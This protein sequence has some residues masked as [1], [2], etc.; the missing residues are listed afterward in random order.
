M[1]QPLVD[2]HEAK[3]VNHANHNFNTAHV[4]HKS[5][6]LFTGIP[7]NC[8]IRHCRCNSVRTALDVTSSSLGLTQD[9]FEHQVI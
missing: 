8:H 6:Y 3:K 5:L 2:M 4:R 7:G 9:A 1:L